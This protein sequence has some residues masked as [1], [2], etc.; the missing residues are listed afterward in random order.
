MAATTDHPN[1]R[2]V[3]DLST[4]HLPKA[5][6]TSPDQ[7]GEGTIYLSAV[8]GVVADPI[9]YGYLM[10]VPDDPDDHAAGYDDPEEP[11]P[12]VVLAVQIYAR[13]LGCDW[14]RFDRDADVADDLP[15]WQW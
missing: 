5:L 3:L 10:W 13:E 12:A 1:V 9:K 15:T 4:A 6:G 7:A 2:R 8:D 14:V 11:F